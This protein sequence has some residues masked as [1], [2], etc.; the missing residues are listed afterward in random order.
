M[1]HEFYVTLVSKDRVPILFSA[2]NRVCRLICCS[3][4]AMEAPREAQ[5]TLSGTDGSTC[6]CCPAAH[7]IPPLQR[8]MWALPHL[9]CAQ[10]ELGHAVQASHG[11]DTAVLHSAELFILLFRSGRVCTPLTQTW[12]CNWRPNKASGKLYIILSCGVGLA[13]AESRWNLRSCSNI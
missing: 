2:Q 9:S 1:W 11:A 13:E 4:Q 7:G 6:S 5:M 8:E 12:V 10:V 3:W